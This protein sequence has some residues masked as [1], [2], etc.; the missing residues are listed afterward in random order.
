M[1]IIRTVQGLC[2]AHIPPRR[3]SAKEH[4]GPFLKALESRGSQARKEYKKYAKEFIHPPRRLSGQL[5]GSTSGRAHHSDLQ[6]LRSFADFNRRPVPYGNRR[7]NYQNY[8]SKDDNFRPGVNRLRNKQFGNVTPGKV[9]NLEDLIGSKNFPINANVRIR[10]NLPDKPNMRILRQPR[11]KPASPSTLLRRFKISS[12]QKVRIEDI[13]EGRKIVNFE[14]SFSDS[15]KIENAKK[16]FY[17]WQHNA[18]VAN[19]LRELCGK[20]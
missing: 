17:E 18:G 5:T 11:K 9:P 14:T 1:V 7:F 20:K 8:L 15:T 12:P 13:V 3:Q 10:A 2:E 6:S 16:A 4:L 19:A